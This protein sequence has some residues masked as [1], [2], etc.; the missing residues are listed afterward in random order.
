M[1]FEKPVIVTDSPESMSQCSACGAIYK[2]QGSSLCSECT[3]L[4]EKVRNMGELPS[5]ENRLTKSQKRR[6]WQKKGKKCQICG[7]EGV[8]GPQYAIH[9]FRPADWDG[10]LNT[11]QVLCA[12]CLGNEASKRDKIFAMLESGEH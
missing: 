4:L 8:G 2:K 1:T 12:T 6:L 7:V 5:R 3:T 9:P 11:V 10:T